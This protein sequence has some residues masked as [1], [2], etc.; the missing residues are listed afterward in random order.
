MRL[1]LSLCLALLAATALAMPHDFRNGHH[2]RRHRGDES[3]PER[4]YTHHLVH[5]SRGRHSEKRSQVTMKEASSDHRRASLWALM[6]T[7]SSSADVAS[8]S[9]SGS[10]NPPVEQPHKMIIM[11]SN[12]C[13]SDW[14]NNSIPLT[15]LF[16]NGGGWDVLPP[17]CVPPGGATLGMVVEADPGSDIINGTAVYYSSTFAIF[18]DFAAVHGEW[19]FSVSYP[20]EAAVVIQPGVIGRKAVYN[21]VFGHPH[22]ITAC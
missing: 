18:M 7:P 8:G 21:I 4:R 1:Y 9:G 3:E 10:T 2:H 19:G 17:C 12:W 13:Q 22:N 14:L 11:F 6:P 15:Y 20:T 5:G 16:Q